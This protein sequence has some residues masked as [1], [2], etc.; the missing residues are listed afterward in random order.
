MFMHFITWIKDISHEKTKKLNCE[1][2]V[3]LP[4]KFKSNFNLSLK[5]KIKFY[6]VNTKDIQTQ[7]KQWIKLNLIQLNGAQWYRRLNLNAK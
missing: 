5:T 4:L 6:I 2:H 1:I 3:F 7:N